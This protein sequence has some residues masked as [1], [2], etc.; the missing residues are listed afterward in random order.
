MKTFGQ[1][2][3]GSLYMMGNNSHNIKGIRI[4]HLSQVI[5]VDTGKD[6]QEES[7]DWII[8]DILG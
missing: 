2:I 7:E 6:N 5:V 3:A 8:E 4:K 1:V